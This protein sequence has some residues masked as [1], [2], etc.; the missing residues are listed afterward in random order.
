MMKDK[1]EEM[2]DKIE[3]MQDVLAKAERHYGAAAPFT[4]MRQLVAQIDK[5]LE[6]FRCASA[7][8]VLRRLILVCHETA[9]VS[10]FHAD[11][12]VRDVDRT[13]AL[14]ALVHSEVSEALEEVRERG[15]DVEIR[16]EGDKPVGLLSELADVVIRIFDF[17]GELDECFGEEVIFA[18]IE[19]MMAK[20]GYNQKRE[21]MHGKHL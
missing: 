11:K 1:I 13:A 2:Q 5:T 7:V 18:F 21:K 14:L 12:N 4:Q 6:V 20:I 17:V 19:A 8:P 9:V 16:Y 3:E 10:G 15:V